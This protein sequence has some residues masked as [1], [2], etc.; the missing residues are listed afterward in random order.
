MLKYLVCILLPVCFL[1]SSCATDGSKSRV[2]KDGEIA[3]EWTEQ[4]I[5]DNFIFA[6]GIG[7][8]DQ[9]M[10][11]KTQKM[12][13]SRNAAIVGAQY[14]LLSLVKGVKLEG[15]ITVEKA[16]ETDSLLATKID[17]EIK[18]AEVVKSEWTADDGCVTTIRLPKTRLKSMGLNVKDFK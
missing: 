16:M 8:A 12:A 1:L 3:R 4:G 5:T 17:A 14:N 15:G 10:T 11:S 6:T 13:T 7:A 9:T 2:S 18:G